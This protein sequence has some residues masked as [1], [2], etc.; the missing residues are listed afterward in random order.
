MILIPIQIKIYS[1]SWILHSVEI[2]C[3]YNA[4]L[5]ED[6]WPPFFNFFCMYFHIFYNKFLI[7][8][9]VDVPEQLKTYYRKYKDIYKKKINEMGSLIFNKTCI[10]ENL[11]LTFAFMILKDYISLL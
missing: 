4:R 11:C 2:L 6:Q 5:V 9:V 8:L 10:I 7:V 1:I 3:N